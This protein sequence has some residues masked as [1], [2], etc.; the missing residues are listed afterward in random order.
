[1]KSKKLK[2]KKEEL[3]NELKKWQEMINKKQKVWFGKWKLK[4]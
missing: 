1:M 2:W 3:K 4:N